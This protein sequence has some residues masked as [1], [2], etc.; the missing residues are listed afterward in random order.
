M[1]VRTVRPVDL[2]LVA[3]AGP[4]TNDLGLRSQLSLVVKC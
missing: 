3:D 2:T 4:S 1:T